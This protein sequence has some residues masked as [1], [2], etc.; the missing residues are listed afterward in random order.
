MW[1][2]VVLIVVAVLLVVLWSWY[3]VFHKPKID[4]PSK[5]KYIFVT[6]AAS[7]IGKA[8]VEKLL[9]EGCSVYAADINK[10]LLEESF[11][12]EKKVTLIPLDITSPED[13]EKAVEIVKKKIRAFMVSPIA[14]EYCRL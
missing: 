8:T 13:I 3:W 7:G 10:Q 1:A 12:N 2:V 11:K 5:D 14:Q 6:G 4:I 9:K